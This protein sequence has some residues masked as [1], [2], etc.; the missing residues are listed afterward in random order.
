MSFACELHRC[1]SS[2]SCVIASLQKTNPLKLTSGR[3][4]EPNNVVFF[5]AI[6]YSTRFFCSRK[7]GRPSGP[8]YQ[9]GRRRRTVV[10]RKHHTLFP[11]R[12]FPSFPRALRVWT[13]MIW[14]FCRIRR[15]SLRMLLLMSLHCF[16]ACGV[17]SGGTNAS[18]PS[19][20]KRCVLPNVCES[21]QWVAHDGM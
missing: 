3:S 10:P 13:Q 17:H 14:R 2:G 1:P 4:A 21:L 15:L 8:N 19:M 20:P 12:P 16:R 9:S 5:S 11:L 18:R 6:N 7:R